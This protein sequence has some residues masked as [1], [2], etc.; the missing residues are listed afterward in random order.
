MVLVRSP[1]WSWR[2]SSLSKASRES[3]EASR[4]ATILNIIRKHHNGFLHGHGLERGRREDAQAPA[5]ARSRQPYVRHAHSP[6]RVH[7]AAS[8]PPPAN[9]NFF[10]PSA[11]T[12]LCL[13]FS[14][15]P[16]PGLDDMEA[17][18]PTRLNVIDTFYPDYNLAALVG[19]KVTLLEV[20]HLQRKLPPE[21]L[22]ERFVY[23]VFLCVDADRGIYERV[24]Y[25]VVWRRAAPEAFVNGGEEVV[26]TV[27]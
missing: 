24:G 25:L 3:N 8:S 22:L 12:P 6:S 2:T 15:I 23:L 7:A 5:R 19:C 10:R 4:P 21:L 16:S 27:V 20:L 1:S 18:H 9:P 14:R 13:R 17:T 11:C 26:L